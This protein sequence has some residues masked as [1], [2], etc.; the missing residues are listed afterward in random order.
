MDVL[1]IDRRDE[2]LVDP[3]VDREGQDVRL[4]LDVL[5]LPYQLRRPTRIGEQLI[6]ETCRGLEM[7]RQLIEEVEELL[8]ARDQA[9][10][11]AV[12]VQVESL[13]KLPGGRGRSK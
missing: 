2:A 9:A 4:M 5:D 13:E 12:R 11:H 1:A 7:L 8:I 10:Q 6:E 3:R